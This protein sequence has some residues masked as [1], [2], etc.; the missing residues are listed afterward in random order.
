MVEI[1]FV[2]MTTEKNMMNKDNT[3]MSY[4]LFVMKK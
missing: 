3:R 2:K 4:K 1:K